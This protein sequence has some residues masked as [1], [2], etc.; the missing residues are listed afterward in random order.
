MAGSPLILGSSAAHLGAIMVIVVFNTLVLI[1]FQEDF[2]LMVRV[3]SVSE[4]IF[5]RKARRLG[6]GGVALTL[7]SHWYR[8]LSC[9][10]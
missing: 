4:L 8:V 2:F 1:E 9:R 5:Q 3:S 7:S 10:V 6:H